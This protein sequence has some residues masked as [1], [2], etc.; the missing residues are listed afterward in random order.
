MNKLHWGQ[1]KL[2]KSEQ[3]SWYNHYYYDVP[4]TGEYN[5]SAIWNALF[6]NPKF[7]RSRYVSVGKIEDLG[8]GR[9]RIEKICHLGD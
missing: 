4:F 8:D 5:G 2:F 9:V 1:K 3:S 6:D 7:G